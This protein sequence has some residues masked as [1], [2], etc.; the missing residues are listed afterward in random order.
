MNQCQECGSDI[1]EVDTFCPFCGISLDRAIPKKTAEGETDEAADGE[2]PAEPS[3]EII[4]TTS[5]TAPDPTES[6][7]PGDSDATAVSRAEPSEKSAATPDDFVDSSTLKEGEESEDEFASADDFVDRSALKAD[8]E[9]E[10]EFASADD[11][12][13]SSVFKGVEENEDEF[14]SAD[15][16]SKAT[17]VPGEAGDESPTSPDAEPQ[18]P[19]TGVTSED[20]DPDSEIDQSSSADFLED[21][22]VMMPFPDL[23]VVDKAPDGKSAEMETQ[24]EGA[25][26]SPV[27]QGDKSEE[28]VSESTGQTVGSDPGTV[29]TEGETV[30]QQSAGGAE[31]TPDPIEPPID[32]PVITGD[33]ADSSESASVASSVPDVD[34][35]APKKDHQ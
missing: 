4:D 35:P 18:L 33:T 27:E 25:I 20:P 6:D 7:V 17:S 24:V 32:I 9:S 11:F 26:D 31:D 2:A 21:N 3:A 30:V 22:T 5:T 13:D 28:A 16:S 10:D 29:D 14:A 8:E 15:D 34:V 19:T 12:V 23:P 1:A